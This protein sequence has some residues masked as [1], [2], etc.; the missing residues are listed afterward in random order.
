MDERGGFVFEKED[1][2]ERIVFM[3]DKHTSH[4]T[5]THVNSTFERGAGR[6]R[7]GHQRTRT[8]HTRQQD[9]ILGS[10]GNNSGKWS[11]EIIH[12]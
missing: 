4:I 7:H 1:V 8:E 6:H 3:I 10:F 12:E 9:P 5:L 11:L 2:L